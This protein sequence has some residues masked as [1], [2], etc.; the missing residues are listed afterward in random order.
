VSRKCSSP[1]QMYQIWKDILNRLD[2]DV[3]TT[4]HDTGHDLLHLLFRDPD[5]N[6]SKFK[7]LSMSIRLSKMPGIYWYSVPGRTQ[8]ILDDYMKKMQIK[9]Q[10]DGFHIRAAYEHK[11]VYHGPSRPCLEHHNPNSAAFMTGEQCVIQ[12]GVEAEILR[13]VEQGANIMADAAAL[14]RVTT[15]DLSRIVS[16]GQQMRVENRIQHDCSKRGFFINKEQLR[17]PPLIVDSAKYNSFPDPPQLPN[18]S[19][20]SRTA[21]YHQRFVEA[22]ERNPL[23]LHMPFVTIKTAP[24]PV[25]FPSVHIMPPLKSQPKYP[26][27]KKEEKSITGL[28]QLDIFGTDISDMPQLKKR[29]KA[30]IKKKKYGGGH[31]QEP[32]PQFYDDPLERIGNLDFESLYPNIIIGNVLCYSI[33]CYD[34]RVLTDPTLSLQFVEVYEGDS[35]ILVTHIQGIP[36]DTLIPETEKELVAERKRVKRLMKA[37]GVQVEKMLVD[38]NLPKNTGQPEILAM[39]RSGHDRIDLL[40]LVVVQMVNYTNFD[41]QQLG[42][43]IVQNAVFGFMGVDDESGRMP[44]VVLMAAITAIGRWMIKCTAWYSIRYYQAA[45]N[46][47]DTVSLCILFVYARTFV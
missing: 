11:K 29:K 5:R 13:F 6:L 17:I 27:T 20:R 3:L 4:M 2:V 14:S 19:L 39:I 28:R 46:Y 35:M 40:K 15:T 42:S 8:L 32:I 16:N 12:C 41:K 33:T 18:V 7:K 22:V 9:P 45:V 31:V 24:D 34:K 30:N 21:E 44:L 37:A 23:P 43:K 25:S 38:L 47:G 1:A 26:K 10:F 36:I